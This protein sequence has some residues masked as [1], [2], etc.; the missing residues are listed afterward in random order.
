MT[1]SQLA[2]MSPLMTKGLGIVERDILRVVASDAW[3]A[4][5]PMTPAGIARDADGTAK[6]KRFLTRWL[7]MYSRQS[8]NR[9]FLRLVQKG[10]VTVPRRYMSPGQDDIVVT[11]EGYRVLVA[12]LSRSAPAEPSEDS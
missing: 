8:I 11:P 6:P 2:T 12:L 4:A 7:P 10:L 3:K 5:N 9:A 1:A